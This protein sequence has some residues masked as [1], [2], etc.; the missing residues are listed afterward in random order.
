[1]GI[2]A[3]RR[4]D[5][6]AARDALDESLRL[7]R[8][9]GFKEEIART[10]DAY[11]L[12]ASADGEH[13]LAARLLGAAEALGEALNVRL[14]RFEQSLH[15]EAVAA[16]SAELGAHGFAHEVSHGRSTPMEDAVSAA[17]RE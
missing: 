3:L 11:A 8:E 12:L 5:A 15:D 14:D 6:N 2:T 10:L 4:D 16:L 13:L 17:L 7:S 9:L 1:V